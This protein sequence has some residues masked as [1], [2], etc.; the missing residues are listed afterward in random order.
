MITG[1]EAQTNLIE[2]AKIVVTGLRTRAHGLRIQLSDG[3]VVSSRRAGGT[4]RAFARRCSTR[5]V[6][7]RIPRSTPLM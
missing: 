6:G 1:D 4:F 2:T 3:F 5:T 7:F